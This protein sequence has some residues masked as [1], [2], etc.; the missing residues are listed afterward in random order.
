MR[1]SQRLGITS[2]RSALQGRSLD[3]P[4]RNRLWS[5][6]ATTVPETRAR[7]VRD[8][9][10][11]Q[12]YASI[13]T[14]YFKEPLDLMP[15]ND[16]EIRARLRA[17]F[18]KGEWYETY[19]IVEFA[20]ACEAHGNRDRFKELVT[21]ILAEE[22]AGFR[23][24]GGQ[25]VEITDE[26]E[27][28]AI[29][30]AF[31]ASAA[32]RFAPARAHLSTALQLLS[33]R[34]DPDYRNSIKESISAVEAIAQILSGSPQSELGRAIAQLEKSR[35]MHGALKKALL[36]VYGY[37]SDAEGIRHALT[38]EPNLDAADAQ[39]MLVACSAFL[40]YLIQKSA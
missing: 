22:Q 39:F 10:M 26:S 11:N 32:D 34:R 8:T 13:W 35:P 21:Q 31:A 36:A 15:T 17:E 29:E 38:E 16:T 14:D 27:L 9:W 24:I 40:V 37:T 6:F 7:H 3:E 19:D 2:V 18:T 4:T 25:F 33:D 28:R 1:L 23:W 12:V 20:L 30:E 5:A